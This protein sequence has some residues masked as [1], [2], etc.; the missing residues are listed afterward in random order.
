MGSNPSLYKIYFL[1]SSH[2]LANVTF[3]GK[4]ANKGPSKGLFR[5]L[6]VASK[7]GYL[8]GSYLKVDK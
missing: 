3:K 2:S 7:N 8:W 4:V 1:L 5:L 6:L